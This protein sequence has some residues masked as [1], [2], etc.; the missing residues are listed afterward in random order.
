[1]HEVTQFRYSFSKYISLQIKA[2]KVDIMIVFMWYFVIFCN[3]LDIFGEKSK[4]K[5][6]FVVLGR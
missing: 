1:M 4:R 5:T 2:G 3:A 6:H